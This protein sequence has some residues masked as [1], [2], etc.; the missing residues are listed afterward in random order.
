MISSTPAF[1]AAADDPQRKPAKRFTFPEDVTNRTDKMIS[2]GSFRQ[3]QFEGDPLTAPTIDIELINDSKEFNFLITDKQSQIGIAAKIEIG[4]DGEWINRFRGF[5]ERPNFTSADRP[6][7]GMFFSGR[8]QATL[9]K[10]IGS[11]AS[12]ISYY[13]NAWNP[14]DM[15]WDIL[16]VYGNLSTITS[17]ANPDIDYPSW[18]SFKQICEDLRYSLRANFKGETVAEAMR[19]IGELVDGIIYGETDGKIYFKREIPNQASSP[20]LFSDANAH[21]SQAETYYNKDR[22][23]NQA[24]VWWGYDPVAGNWIIG[25]SVANNNSSSQSQQWGLHKKDFDGTLVWHENAVSADTFGERYVARYGNLLDVVRFTSKRGTQALLHQIGDV[26]SLTWA[27]MDFSVKPLKIY[28]ITAN[29]SQ[30]QWEILAEDFPS[31][32]QQFFVLDSGTN[33]I[34]DTNIF[35]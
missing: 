28:G 19:T 15:A 21:L 18:Q 4:F 32:S 13:T 8:V 14:A 22:L 31:A 35:Y 6:K 24:I 7:C 25:G 20:Y 12:E 27:Q 30:D 17:T 5:F 23:W 29:L 3:E 1:R 9:E 11:S 10:T 33:G 26:I 2:I 34:L 16:T